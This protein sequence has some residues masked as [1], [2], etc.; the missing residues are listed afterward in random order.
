MAKRRL[1]RAR[2]TVR[3]STYRGRAGFTVRGRVPDSLFP[4]RV[5]ALDEATAREIAAVCRDDTLTAGERSA[6]IDAALRAQGA[7]TSTTE[8]EP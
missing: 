4:V 2:I 1:T 5:F 6:R 7:K 8:R 3:A